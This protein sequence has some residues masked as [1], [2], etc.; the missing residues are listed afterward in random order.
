MVPT[1]KRKTQK[2]QDARQQNDLHIAIVLDCSGSMDMVRD[3]TISGFNEQVQTIR[4]NADVRDGRTT[5]SLVLFN[6]SVDVVHKLVP[7]DAVSEISRKEYRPEILENDD[8][9]PLYALLEWTGAS[10]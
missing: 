5:V 6:D 10:A 3:E 9:C 4:G 8:V 2:K 1:T 7:A